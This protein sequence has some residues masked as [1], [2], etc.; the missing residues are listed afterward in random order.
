[1]KKIFTKYIMN[2]IWIIVFAVLAVYFS[3]KGDF[4]TVLN[5]VQGANFSWVFF[6][7]LLIMIYQVIEG[8]ILYSFGKLYNTNYTFKQ[9]CINS[10]TA[11]F[12][13]GITPFQSGG[14]F[15]QVYVFN[16]QGIMPS[17]AASILLM[18]FIVYQSTVV[19]YTLIILMTRF[20]YYT[21][22]FSSIF[23]LALIG[24]G[25]SFAV[26]CSLFL[27]AK[28]KLLQN[29]FVKVVL[30]MGAKVRII[31]DY[32][33][34]VI[35]CERQ[36]E[37][38]R[39]ELNN[40]SKNKDILIIATL[41]NIVKLTILYAIPFFCAKALGIHLPPIAL[42]ETIGICAFIYMITSFVPIPGASGGS[43][44]I[45]VI[46]FSFLFGNIGAKSSMLVW[47]FVTYYFAMFIGA[48]VFSLDKEINRKE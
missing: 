18:N 37:D 46:M 48:L 2:I 17:Y 43:E 29:F 39:K 33:S 36:L 35:K 3:L 41:G 10:I 4:E 30:K 6:S 9:G 15:A 11:T 34:S 44:G 12:F 31:K 16:K 22:N 27:G 23:S 42:F 5:I 1:M 38:F 19:L 7:I 20:K 8:G 14:Q 28:S 47:R 13:N 26:I 21:L 32:E 24:F 40:L 45:F 25:I